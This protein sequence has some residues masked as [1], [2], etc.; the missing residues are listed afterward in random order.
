MFIGRG[1]TRVQTPFGGAEFNLSFT[2][3]AAFRSSE[4]RTKTFSLTYKH[5]A[6]NGAKTEQ[7]SMESSQ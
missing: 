3:T 2:T 7:V 4:R 5:L 1:S 6:P